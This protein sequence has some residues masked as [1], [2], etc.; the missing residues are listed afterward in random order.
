MT[1]SLGNA[2]GFAG[3][4]TF[5]KIALK[6]ALGRRAALALSSLGW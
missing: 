2:S 4:Y 6:V 1:I 3:G 5:A